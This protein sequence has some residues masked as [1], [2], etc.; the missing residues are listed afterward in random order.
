[1]S[2][3]S[4]LYVCWFIRV[5]AIHDIYI[6]TCTQSDGIGSSSQ[7]CDVHMLTSPNGT[8]IL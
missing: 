2:E 5:A 3:D 8:K 4:I 1:M 7:Y 6:C